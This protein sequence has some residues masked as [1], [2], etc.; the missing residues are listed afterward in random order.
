LS[1][2]AGSVRN[3]VPRGAVVGAAVA[4]AVLLAAAVAGR[5]GRDGPPLDPRSDGPLG[6][7]ALVSLL[8]HLGARVDLSVGLPDGSNDLALLLED[9]LDDRQAGEVQAWVQAGGTLVV[10]DPSSRFAPPV[11]DRSSVLGSGE[12]ERGT[13]SIQALRDVDRVDGGAAVRFAVDRVDG[14]CFGDQNSAFVVVTEVGAG[15]LAAVGGAAFL[16][17]DLLDAADNAVLAATLLAPRSSTSVRFLD[18][19]IPAGGGDKTL[20]ELVPDGLKRALLQL[21]VAFVLYALWRAIRLGRPVPDAQPVA[22]A[23]YELVAAIGRLLS[24][25]R[26]PGSAA[27]TLRTSLRSTLRARLGVPRDAPPATLA[28]IV[29]ARTGLPADVVATAIG[30]QPV[31]TD[32]ELVAVARAAAAIHQEV[33]R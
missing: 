21:G 31:T 32:A 25:T 3:R 29:T 23:G 11:T 19:P 18:P 10:V 17:N 24:H 8:D 5:P 28:G 14:S 16:T 20:G 2:L 6:T 22:V 26:D 12:V 4:A 9:H 33:P 27:A 15:H 7:S 1:A 13:C 30:E